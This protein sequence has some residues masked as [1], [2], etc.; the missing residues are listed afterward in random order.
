MR[1][2]IARLMPGARELSAD[3]AEIGS[4]LVSLLVCGLPLEERDLSAR[5]TD[6]FPTAG[7]FSGVSPSTSNG[8]GVRRHYRSKCHF[9][10]SRAVSLFSSST[11]SATTQKPFEA[12]IAARPQERMFSS[13]S[14]SAAAVTSRGSL[15]IA[16]RYA[17]AKSGGTWIP[18]FD[19]Q[20]STHAGNWKN[21][22]SAFVG[23]VAR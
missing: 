16:S 17:G 3:G 9:K 15:A 22:K 10:N 7:P 12:A 1:T 23:A 11:A 21:E 8:S 14:R 5:P 13:Q 19:R 20:I 2:P 18:C 6:A 4:V